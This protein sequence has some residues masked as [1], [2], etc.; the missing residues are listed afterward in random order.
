MRDRISTEMTTLWKF[1]DECE[2][3]VRC[4]ET[5]GV[6]FNSYGTLLC[7]IL[8]KMIPEDIAL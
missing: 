6:V 4:F 5:M 2:I 3:Q 8:M 7:T 1:Y